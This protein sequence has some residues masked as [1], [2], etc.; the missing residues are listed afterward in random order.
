MS[1]TSAVLVA[2]ALSAC[3]AEGAD[4]VATELVRSAQLAEHG[5]ASIRR[6]LAEHQLGSRGFG[7]GVRAVEQ[8]TRE[9]AALETDD[10]ATDAQR[11]QALVL[12]AR[13][14]DDTASAIDAAA[15][16]DGGAPLPA[17]AEALRD[18]SFPARIAARNGFERALRAACAAGADP[19]VVPELLDGIARNGGPTLA[20]DQACR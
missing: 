3:A 9:L 13:A 16:P 1:R 20:A 6:A 10:R 15:E 18:K 7:E 14:W 5:V 11:L 2:A 4:A 17:R 12:Q 19:I 8:A